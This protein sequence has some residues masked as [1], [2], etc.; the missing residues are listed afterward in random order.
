MVRRYAQAFGCLVGAVLWAGTAAAVPTNTISPPTTD[1]QS[2][3]LGYLLTFGLIKFSDVGLL[4]GGAFLDT[5]TLTDTGLFPS[6][7]G[8]YGGSTLT[9]TISL[10][11]PPTATIA[12]LVVNW[13]VG[14]ILNPPIATEQVTDGAGAPIGPGPGGDGELTVGV[15]AGLTYFLTLSGIAESFGSQYT[16]SITPTSRQGETPL[17]AG[18]ILFGTVLG[19]AGMLMRRRKAARALA[20]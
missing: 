7:T 10:A 18:F 2:S 6:E 4:S 20:V 16:G 12:D 11:A 13:Y 5:Y 17:P 19:G 3:D 15:S 9:T 8:P 14:S 1:L